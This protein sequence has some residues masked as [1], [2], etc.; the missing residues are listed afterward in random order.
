MV[1][2]EEIGID[3]GVAIERQ[4]GRECSILRRLFGLAYWFGTPILWF[5]NRR[6][7]V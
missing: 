7:L 3:H 5:T 2:I 1:E 6:L 4:V